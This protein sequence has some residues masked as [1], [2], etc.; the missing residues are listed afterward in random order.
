ME[1]NRLCPP[2]CQVKKGSYL[3]S[4]GGIPDVPVVLPVVQ[5][6]DRKKT[7]YC[8]VLEYSTSRSTTAALEMRLKSYLRVLVRGT[9]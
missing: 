6:F 5:D 9:K 8:V 1:K 4:R 7:T 3:G 2:M